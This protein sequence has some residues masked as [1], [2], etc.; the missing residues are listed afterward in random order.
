MVFIDDIL[1]YSQSREEHVEHLSI[2]LHSQIK[3][4]VRQAEQVRFLAR[5]NHFLGPCDL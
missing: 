3:I 4:I 2:V 1:V 5:Q